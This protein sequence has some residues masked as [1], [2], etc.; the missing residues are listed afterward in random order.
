M[1]FEERKFSFDHFNAETQA[2]LALV[3]GRQLIL[4]RSNHAATRCRFWLTYI[5][6]FA[7]RPDSVEFP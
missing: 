5:N 2:K 3:S 6:F 1:F 7:G 4:V